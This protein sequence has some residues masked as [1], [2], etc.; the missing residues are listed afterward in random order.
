VIRF[1]TDSRSAKMTHLQENSR[2]FWTFYDPR[3]QVQLRLWGDVQIHQEDS[4][5][6]A[7][8]LSMPDF[9]KKDYATHQAPGSSMDE[10][11][12]GQLSND[13]AYEHFTVIETE[14]AGWEWLQLGRPQH[15]RA[16]FSRVENGDK[17]HWEGD[18]LVP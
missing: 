16:I 6:Q 8:W 7:L 4:L 5:C 1:Y 11:A 2:V 14:I 17:V 3:K 10:L 9:S 12:T 13:K 15:Q 18:W